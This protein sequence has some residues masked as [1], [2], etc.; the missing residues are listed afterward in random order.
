[1]E[2]RGLNT[3]TDYDSRAQAGSGALMGRDVLPASGRKRGFDWFAPNR[4]KGV[5]QSAIVFA[6]VVLGALLMQPRIA[7][8]DS[9][10]CAYIEGAYSIQAG[11]GYEDLIGHRLNH[12][13]PGYSALLSVFS[14]PLWAALVIN[15]LSLGVAAVSIYLLTQQ[16]GWQRL[17]SGAVALALGFGFLRSLASRA[18]PDILTYAIFLIG[19]LCLGSARRWWRV[20]GVCLWSVLIPLKLIAIVFAPALLLVDGCLLRG[21]P[22]GFRFVQWGIV[23][24]IWLTGVVAVVGFNYYTMKVFVP[25]THE[26]SN[27]SSFA[28]EAVRFC[29]DFFR[30]FLANWYGSIRKIEVWLPFLLT[31][32]VAVVCLTTLRPRLDGRRHLYLGAALLGLSWVLE[33]KTHF[34]ADPRLMGYG[35]LVLLLGF[36]PVERAYKRWLAYAGC[37]MILAF[38]NA[39]TTNSLGIN[40]ARYEHLAHEV[41]AAQ[42]SRGPIVS[43]SYH[44]FEIHARVPSISVDSL[45][46]V[47][48]GARFLRIDLP[49]YDAIQPTV[50]RIEEPPREWQ[51]V[52]KWEGATLYVKPA[53]K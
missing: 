34:Y 11:H 30:A 18:K 19:M 3:G 31:V 48:L 17:A 47:P 16:A 42:P 37:T 27:V 21:R 28:Q 39:F 45:D 25:A 33:V 12:W 13:P 10:A 29:V 9:D 38:A 2:T 26:A 49:S 36:R 50:W 32:M 7:V 5:V 46:Q 52:A 4:T 1:M 43:N 22:H 6:L 20:L 44:I 24:G 8:S 41:L 35:L 53:T 51:T 23:L 40:D 14:N 15:Y